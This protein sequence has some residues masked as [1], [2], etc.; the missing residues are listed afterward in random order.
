MGN[1]SSGVKERG[2][3]GAAPSP[4]SV[5][6]LHVRYSSIKQLPLGNT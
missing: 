2:H 5:R 3:G 4:N 6:V 1:K